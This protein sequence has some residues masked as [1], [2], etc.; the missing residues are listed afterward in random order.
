MA[1]EIGYW[2]G[3]GTLDGDVGGGAATTSGGGTYTAGAN[4]EVSYV[5]CLGRSATGDAGVL[6]MALVRISD[7]YIEQGPVTFNP[8][9]AAGMAEYGQAVSWPLTNGVEYAI[10]VRAVDTATGFTYYNT[11]STGDQ[12]VGTQY[13]QGETW[14]AGTGYGNNRRFEAAADVTSTGSSVSIAALTANSN[15]VIQ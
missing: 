1:N 9:Y 4:E 14:S 3:T 7:N 11:G 12:T 10:I 8:T 13:T 6:K 15:Q 5:R 2:T